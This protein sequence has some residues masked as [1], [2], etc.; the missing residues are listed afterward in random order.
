[1][2]TMHAA[3]TSRGLSIQH[4]RYDSVSSCRIDPPSNISYL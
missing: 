2:D 1:M 4:Y 3:I